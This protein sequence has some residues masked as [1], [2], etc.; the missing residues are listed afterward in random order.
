MTRGARLGQNRLGGVET[1]A[2]LLSQL[3]KA[4]LAI[5]GAADDDAARQRRDK[6]SADRRTAEDSRVLLDEALDEALLDQPKD[7]Q[8]AELAEMLKALLARLGEGTGA[9][10]EQMQ[11]V[12]E[13]LQNQKPPELDDVA[14]E[15]ENALELGAESRMETTTG[16]G[17]DD[18]KLLEDAIEADK[19][20]AAQ[21]LEKEKELAREALGGDED[22]EARHRAEFEALEQQLASAGPAAPGDYGYDSPSGVEDGPAGIVTSSDVE[23]QDAAAIRAVQERERAALEA[24]L[25][26][27]AARKKAALHRRLAATR[28]AR[29]AKGD[30]EK[31]ISDDEAKELADLDA[32]SSEE[33]KAALEQAAET[34]KALDLTDPGSAMDKAHRAELAARSGADPDDLEALKQRQANEDALMAQ[35]QA[36]KKKL[37]TRKADAE[38]DLLVARAARRYS[39]ETGRGGAAAA[40]W[41]LRGDKSRRRRGR[42]VD[43]P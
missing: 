33:A 12:L 8:L 23:E 19:R 14:E 9:T 21:E 22:L 30:A 5:F 35:S 4:L 2:E 43:I 26:D 28:A 7:A 16:L 36:L 37:G 42:D 15:T 32:A 1:F 41:I 18:Q 27:Q 13:Q 17:A 38:F 6:A 31:A 10:S 40:T 20:R 25:K 34:Q 29:L 24:K 39:V 11:K 3:A